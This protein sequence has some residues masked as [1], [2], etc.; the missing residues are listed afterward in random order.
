VAAFRVH[1]QSPAQGSSV[2][3]TPSGNVGIGTTTP[4]IRLQVQGGHYNSRIRLFSDEYGQG[5]D[6]V[7]TGI[8]SLWTSEP[9]VTWNG[10]GIG[11]NI[12]NYEGGVGGSFPRITTTRGGSYIRLL[13]NA[14]YLNVVDSIGVDRNGIT[15]NNSAYVGIGTT[16]P[17]AK[18]SVN[19]GIELGSRIYPG[20]LLTEGGWSLV[21]FKGG[22]VN[23]GG[24]VRASQGTG[25]AGN[26]PLRLQSSYTAMDSPVI[27]IPRPNNPS[28]LFNGMMWMCTNV[29]AAGNCVP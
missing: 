3:I 13:D 9:G 5:I 10:I 27:L 12:Q 17:A 21:H 8:F 19:G 2:R 18:L 29:D 26:A 4:Q 15:I 11:N 28:P 24:I 7:N 1:D 25:D 23:E 20:S 16:S 22:T 6:G 14:M